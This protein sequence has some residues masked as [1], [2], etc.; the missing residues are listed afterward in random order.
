VIGISG[1]LV[2]WKGQDR[3]IGAI[4]SLLAGGHDVHGLVVGGEGFGLDPG[5]ERELH[6]LARDLGVADRIAF[7]GHVEDPLAHTQAMDIAVNASEGEPFG[8]VVLEAMGLCIPTLAV[9][10]GGPSEIIEDGRTGVLVSSNAPEALAGGL[11]RLL[12]DPEGRRALGA[13]GRERVRSRFTL[14]AFATG[15][16]DALA[17]V[18]AGQW[19]SSTRRP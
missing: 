1:R 3:L 19:A 5:Y 18:P 9:A 17:G 10:G 16:R 6:G 8:L 4:A 7:T 13:A 15:V 2:R 12:D 11:E 14:D